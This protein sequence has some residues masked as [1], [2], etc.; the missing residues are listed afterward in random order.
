MPSY[1]AYVLTAAETHQLDGV[2]GTLAI[3]NKSLTVPAQVV[4][5]L[6]E[7][8]AGGTSETVTLTDVGDALTANTEKYRRVTITANSY[9]MTLLY[10][11]A[12]SHDIQLSS[13]S[14]SVKGGVVAAGAF[15]IID[16]APVAVGLVAVE[17]PPI[18][19]QLGIVLKADPANAGIIYIAHNAAVAATSW[20]L[21]ANETFAIDSGVSVWAIASLAAQTLHVWRGA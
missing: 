19:G 6:L 10:A 17:I 15:G 3:A 18:A 11:I 20:P 4:T 14:A 2:K 5:V 16:E 13:F 8:I 9:P 7:P 1:T 12:P 21:A